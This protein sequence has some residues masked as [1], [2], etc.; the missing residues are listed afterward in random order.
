MIRRSVTYNPIM[1]DA[2]PPPTLYVIDGFSQI[3]RAYYAIMGGM[4]SPVTGEPTGAAFGMAGMFIK[5]FREFQPHYIIMAVD[6]PGKTFRD[7]LYPAYKANREAPPEDLIQ[8][9]PR[10][11]KMAQLFGVPV[12]G[13]P[14]IEADDVIATIT[15]RVLHD[16][17][18]SPSEGLLP[19]VRIVSKDK[20]LEQL[21][22]DRVAMIDIHKDELI[23]VEALKAKK[24]VTP[25]QVVDL[26]TLTGDSADN[27][28]GVPGVGPKTAAKL[29]QEF[30]S[31][32]GVYENI[33]KIKGKRREN[34]EAAHDKLALSRQLVTLKR[35]A[36]FQFSLDDARVGAIHATELRRMF[37]ELG[38]HRHRQDLEQLLE[39]AP[40][41]ASETTDDG[42][43][44]PTGGLF[45]SP[46]LTDTA[47]PHGVAEG[48]TSADDFDY[49]A[50]TTKKQL[51]ELVKT[52]R[53]QK[54][55]SVDTE[56][57]G[58]GHRAALCGVSLAWETGRGV[59]IPIRSPKPDEHLDEATVLKALG[60]MLSDPTVSKCG[61]NLKYDAL[62]LR[63]AGAV[64]HGV[65]F[66]SMIA[67]HLLGMASH[68]LDA[69]ASSELS[70]QMT[71]ISQLIGAKQ[72]GQKQKT[73]DQ[74]PLD[75]ITSY[76]AEDADMALRMYEHF[77]PQI[78]TMGLQRLAAEVEMPLVE[79][80]ADMA[81]TGV[82]VDP[83][84][85]EQQKT[86]LS[87]RVDELRD[88]IFERAGAPFNL[89]SPKQL[90]EVLFN[91]M[92]MPVIKK[93]KT[94]YSTDVEVLEKLAQREDV[95]PR[96]IDVPILI[97]EYRQLTKLVGT[98]LV[99][100]VE[101]IDAKTR[102]VHASFHQTGA[103]TGRLSSSGPNLQNI[104]IRTEVGRQIRKA[105]VAEPGCQLICADYSQIELRVLAHLSNDAGLLEAFQT[106]QDIHAAVAARVF[107]APQD[108]VSPEQR[109][110]AK[111]INFGIIYGITP[112][113]LARRIEGLDVNGARALIE[114]YQQRFPGI[115][116][117]MQQC[118]KRALDTGF[119]ETIL[120]R[121]RPIGQIQ[122]NNPQ[123]RALGERLAINTVVQ[124]SAA[125]LIKLAMVNLHRRIVREKLPM[126]LLLQIHDELV[127][128]AP[129]KDALQL[130][131]IVRGEMESAMSLRAPLKVDLAVGANWFDA[132]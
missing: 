29:L 65:A 11:F 125:D 81:F 33:E 76:A 122:S 83:A 12:I 116:A 47:A 15:H 35:D 106:D 5:L 132:K 101:A 87:A 73:M 78:R 84:V 94:G 42:D 70:H 4:R 100:L 99:A 34:L 17:Q 89:D 62:V 7:E 6:S 63:H 92:N 38:F 16:P 107:D 31:I 20:D 50:I 127:L 1:P 9:I 48:M 85:L 108:Q 79:V 64:L 102:R 23:D 88:R 71:P 14:G 21:L 95:D 60:P 45:D 55:I 28:P 57:I 128:E 75:Q 52:L 39:Q 121:R 98:Y 119:V 18:I 112:F 97:L 13:Q 56:T 46:Q 27:I 120:A 69:L 32:E 2:P 24:G 66:D 123:T 36:A 53:D 41:V 22:G 109:A 25:E 80:L 91:Q 72:R 126:K 130:S 129:Q 49:T 43:A 77:T 103:A 86:E 105:F 26:L 30:G 118:V 59:Y 131:E 44:F 117:F 8:Q 40:T 124:G 96:Y 93:T 115:N 58:L 90:G 68:G 61:H 104:P 74:I 110:R 19:G 113:G 82:R 3:F 10:I 111:V 37:E 51:D 114:E 54:I 67:S